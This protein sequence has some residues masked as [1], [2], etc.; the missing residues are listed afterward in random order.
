ME[1][2]LDVMGCFHQE[3][4]ANPLKT[5]IFVT[6]PIFRKLFF[7]DPFGKD[8]SLPEIDNFFTGPH[9]V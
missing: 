3:F 4:L 9:N 5:E 2:V 1:A 7:F 6:K 8:F